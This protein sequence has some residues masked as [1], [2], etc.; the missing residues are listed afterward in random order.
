MDSEL[1]ALSPQRAL[2]EA[3][4]GDG[5]VDGFDSRGLAV[6]RRNLLAAAARALSISFPTVTRLLGRERL[7]ILSAQFLKSEGRSEFDWGVWGG[8]FPRWLAG[9]PIARQ[10]PYLA[11]TARLDWLMH[12][13]QRAA[14]RDPDY[15]SFSRL[16]SSENFDFS[17]SPAPGYCVLESAFPVVA[18]HEAHRE[19]TGEPDLSVAAAMLEEGRGQAALVWRRGPVTCLREVENDER[20]WLRL[21]EGSAASVAEVIHTCPASSMPLEQWLD[22]AIREQLVI[23][24]SLL[25]PT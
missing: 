15:A 20:I 11:D 22:R 13:A 4:F 14:D 17:L 5:P 3:I 24:L 1:A 8:G 6:Y 9:Q 23:G 12:C 21:L 10:H 18:I 16:A 7:A 19:S 25:N 2:L